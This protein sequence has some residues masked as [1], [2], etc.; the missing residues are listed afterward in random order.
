MPEL[1][2]AHRMHT[3]TVIPRVLYIRRWGLKQTD[4]RPDRKPVMKAVVRPPCKFSSFTFRC[5][6]QAVRTRSIPFAEATPVRPTTAPSPYT[7]VIAQPSV[8]SPPALSILDFQTLLRSYL[9]SVVSCSPILLGPSLRILSLLTHS[10]SPLLRQN[11]ILQFILK[12]TLYKHFCAGETPSEVQQTVAELKGRGF[13]GAIVAY[14]K[15]IVLDEQTAV[16]NCKVDRTS[17]VEA[18][19]NGVLE[20]I[21]LTERGDYAALKYQFPHSLRKRSSTL[22][23]LECCRF[24]GAGFSIIQQLINKSTPGVAISQ[25]NKEICE[26]AKSKGVGLLFDAEQHAVQDGIDQWTLALQR[27]YNR[28]DRAVV[29]GTY[30]AYLRSTP[31]TLARHLTIAQQEGFNLGV[32]L[33]RGA[34]LASDPRHLFWATKEGTDNTFDGIA[35]SLMRK[36][37]N[38]VLTPGEPDVRRQPAFPNVD[39]VLAT[40]SH[41]SVRKAICIRQEQLRSGHGRVSLA[42]AQLMGM[43]DEV[44]CELVQAGKQ[45][46]GAWEEKTEKPR[47]YKYVVWGTVGECLKYLLRRAEENRDALARAKE[48]RAAL[49]KELRRRL[50]RL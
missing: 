12:R 14:A 44:S 9:I 43:A 29:Y 22:A 7:Q 23:N 3:Y 32:K 26:S 49:G 4:S 36:Q 42:Y 15:E 8:S 27:M 38:H 6:H 34:Y 39:I 33:V 17:D 40:H 2:I 5:L 41:E 19:K 25:A 11:R 24:S 48:G 50:L 18:W 37:W 31:A 47:A 35:E 30:Q 20:T 10:T 13:T 45:S 46:D 16:E 1:R 28:G 21:K